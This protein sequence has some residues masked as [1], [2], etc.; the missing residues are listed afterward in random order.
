[1]Y[2][3]LF[4]LF[5]YFITHIVPTIFLIPIINYIYSAYSYTLLYYY[6]SVVLYYSTSAFITMV[7]H[8]QPFWSFHRKLFNK[9]LYILVITFQYTLTLLFLIILNLRYIINLTIVIHYTT[10]AIILVVLY[11]QLLYH[12]RKLEKV[13]IILIRSIVK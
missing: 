11:L 9:I 6:W 1:M 7:L 4:L 3:L 12:F 5:I 2:C 13:Y 8:L 10:L